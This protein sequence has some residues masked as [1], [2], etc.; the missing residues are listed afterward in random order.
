MRIRPNPEPIPL[1]AA[2]QRHQ[3]FPPPK[4]KLVAVPVCEVVQKGATPTQD[5]YLSDDLPRRIRKYKLGLV[6]LGLVAAA[7]IIAVAIVVVT[8]NRNK[9]TGSNVNTD[10]VT[11]ST[12]SA[13]FLT[14]TTS[15]ATPV[16]RPFVT[17]DTFMTSMTSTA[18]MASTTSTTSP[19]KTNTVS[20]KLTV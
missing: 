19:D 16:T 13:T 10:P 3:S 18:I 14:S 8:G 6:S 2:L 1:H 4:A 9:Q 12:T 7:A 17:T 20:G 11:T 15:T 5:N